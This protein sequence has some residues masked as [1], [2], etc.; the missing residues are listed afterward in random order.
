[1]F[2]LSCMLFQ[3]S[4]GSARCGRFNFFSCHLYFPPAW[5]RLAG[6]E[7]GFYD[8]IKSWLC[9]AHEESQKV[10]KDEGL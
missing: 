4:L 1:M 6:F 3:F 8:I 5:L 10:A 7:D 2:L 9:F